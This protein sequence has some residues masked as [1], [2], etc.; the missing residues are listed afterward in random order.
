M[1]AA[2]RGRTGGAQA[3]ALPGNGRQAVA[4]GRRNLRL[5]GCNAAPMAETPATAAPAE[6][7]APKVTLKKGSLV[8]LQRQA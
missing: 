7:A 2:L 3:T 4:A 1:L 8:R 5:P 6:A